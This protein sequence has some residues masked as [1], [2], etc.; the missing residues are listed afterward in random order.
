MQKIEPM[1]QPDVAVWGRV[2]LI[3]WNIPSEVSQP[4]PI[5]LVYG[6]IRVHRADVQRPREGSAGAVNFRRSFALLALHMASLEISK[7]FY[8]RL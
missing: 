8:T 5:R 4:D 6:Q 7:K 1:S 3:S 2:V